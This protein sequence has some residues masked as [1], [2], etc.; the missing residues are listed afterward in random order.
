MKTRIP[1]LILILFLAYTSV[2]GQWTQLNSGTTKNLSAMSQNQAG[3]LFAVSAGSLGI[4]LKSDDNG[5]TWYDV[6][7]NTHGFSDIV[8]VDE[9]TGLAIPENQDT[10][11]RSLDGGNTWQHQYSP[12][13]SGWGYGFPEVYFT[14]SMTGY[15]PGYKTTDG[16]DSW[17]L[18]NQLLNSFPY[19]PNAISFI[20]DST[21]IVAGF[22]YVGV[23]YKTTDYGNTWTAVNI[24]MYTWEIYSLHFPTAQTGYCTSQKF[25]SAHESQIIKTT[26]GGDNWSEIYTT[27]MS[28]LFNSIYCTD[29][30]TCYAVGNNGNILKTIDGGVT[31]GVQNSGTTQSLREVFFTDANTGYIIGDNGIIL[32]TTNAGGATGLNQ[33]SD[34]ENSISLYPNPFHDTFTIQVNLENS[35]CSQF[36]LYN[37]FGQEIISQTLKKNTNIID[38]SAYSNGIY[39]YTLTSETN[40]IKTGR[41]IKQ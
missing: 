34:P 38:L 12:N 39:F 7:A 37:S 33:F 27:S 4:I 29:D 2:K 22:A 31:W 14:D 13:C 10:I 17:F 1:I 6:A 35:P 24:P 5:D 32:K 16:G 11:F 20:N 28:S 8:F 21:G 41:L 19:V 23:N 26:D 36:T 15:S 25:Q 30:N 40:S 3:S 18:Q 9:N